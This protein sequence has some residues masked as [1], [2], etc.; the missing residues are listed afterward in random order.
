VKCSAGWGW[1]IEE[2]ATETDAAVVTVWFWPP[3]V[4]ESA[5][6]R[7]AAEVAIVV[8]WAHA[9]TRRG[10]DDAAVFAAFKGA[11]AFGCERR[12][13]SATVQTIFD[14]RFLIFDL[15]RGFAGDCWRIREERS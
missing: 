4:G 3:A 1:F 7:S 12:E 15:G 8:R 10:K 5:R 2:F 13:W 6:K 11:F 9:E 14:F